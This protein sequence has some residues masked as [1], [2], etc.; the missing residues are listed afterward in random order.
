[1]TRKVAH[2]YHLINENQ[3]FK[4]NHT[5]LK[6]KIQLLEAEL[7]ELKS[8][9][10]MKNNHHANTL[11][12]LQSK[13][14]ELSKAL[15]EKTNDNMKLQKQIYTNTP[16]S[17]KTYNNGD[18]LNGEERVIPH[19]P[20]QMPNISIIPT[21]PTHP[22]DFDRIRRHHGRYYGGY[23][24]FDDDDFYLY[25]DISA[26]IHH[27]PIQK[28]PKQSLKDFV[29]PLLSFEEFQ[30]VYKPPKKPTHYIPPAI[31][32]IIYKEE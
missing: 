20:Q 7:E 21:H 17:K 5:E 26:N 22:K 10:N 31:H 9:I 15:L 14:S 28:P 32:P 2:N 12:F 25:R 11:F 18:F 23:P 30:R 8:Q 16:F 29:N 1:M 6:E 3:F 27:H 24:F 13:N 4:Q 19:H